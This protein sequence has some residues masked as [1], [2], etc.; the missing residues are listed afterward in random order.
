MSDARVQRLLLLVLVSLLAAIGVVLVATR[1]SGP[2]RHDAGLDHL[3]VRRADD[4]AGSARRG[5]R[6]A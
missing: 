5:F 3:A 4:A 6:V 1:R 2:R